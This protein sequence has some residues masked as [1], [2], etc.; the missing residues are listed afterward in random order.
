MGAP[1]SRLFETA[2]G[3]Q[4]IGWDVK[5]I[6]SL[7]NYPT[8]KIFSNY[9]KKIFTNEIL[10]EI[11][12]WRYILYSSNS[13]KS[14][15]RIISMFTFSFMVLLSIFKVRNFKPDYIFTESPPL[16]LGLSGL[17]LAKLSDAKHILNISDLWP[18]SAFELGAI[19]KGFLYRRLEGIESFLYKKS[20]AC[21]GQSEEIVSCLL[22]K[23][24]IR[25]LLFRNGV[26]TNRFQEF[27]YTENAIQNTKVKIVYAGLLGVAQG[28]LELCK[29]INFSD[30]N[31][32]FHIYG[33]GVEKKDI[34][35]YLSEN[36][37]KGIFLHEP[38]HRDLIP[39]TLSKYDATIIPL[40]KPIFGA[41]PSK[42]YEAMAAGLPIIF[43][44]G[45]EGA[46]I[47]EK[48]H[49]GWTCKPSDFYEIQLALFNLGKMPKHELLDRKTHAKN[50]AKQYFDR[51][52]QIEKL[53][54]FLIKEFTK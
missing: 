52:M 40:I 50:I 32:E 27:D 1:Q 41:V 25:T 8:G 21:L 10:N 19:S 37:T 51:M 29:Q 20:F 47:I 45:G 30:F 14:L 49:L 6:T 2:H 24:A 48:L 12:V 28:I 44:G 13:K 42:I 43:S 23:G 39:E 11:Q 33:Q 46:N 9:K 5:V 17:I 38:I 34:E 16:T 22:E 35:L 53:D 4:K 7:P 54:K 26:D 18:L 31:C 3:L 36:S 15:P